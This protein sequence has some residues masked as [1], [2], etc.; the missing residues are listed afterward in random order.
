MTSILP[1]T[2]AK[3]GVLQDMGHTGG[4]RRIGFEA[5]GEDIVFIIT[6][7]MK[8]LCPSLFMLEVECCKLQLGHLLGSFECK[9]VDVV[10]GFQIVVQADQGG[11]I[12]DGDRAWSQQAACLRSGTG[13]WQS[14]M[15]R[16]SSKPS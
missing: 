13:A 12:S 16:P 10:T 2:S 9:A 15:K 11:L 7:D 3:A 6:G 1:R 14:T 5:N 8:V 4:I